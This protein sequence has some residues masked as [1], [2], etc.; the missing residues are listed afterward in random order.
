M[1]ITY[2]PKPWSEGQRAFL[3]EGLEF[4]YSASLKKWVPITPGYAT[5]E[6]LSAAF[7]V[8]TIEQLNTKFAAIEALFY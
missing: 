6:Q 8:E 4:M 2:P 7:E 5:T 3:M 1:K